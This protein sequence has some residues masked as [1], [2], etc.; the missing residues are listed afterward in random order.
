[1]PEIGK[2]GGG[3]IL[4]GMFPFPEVVVDAETLTNEEWLEYRR[5][6]IGGSDA[7][8]LMYEATQYQDKRGLFHE[9]VG[10]PKVIDTNEDKWFIF[11]FGH[12]VEPLVAEMFQ[13]ITG[14]EVYIDTNMYR[15][16]VYKFMQANVDRVV[17]LPDGK[18]ALL[19]CKTTTFF[20]KDVWA[21]GAIP[22]AYE[23]QCRHYMAVMDVDVMFIACIYGNTPG[24]FV[25]RRI[26][27]D[28]EM[29]RDLIEAEK[30]F[31]ENYVELGREPE[32]SGIGELELEF[33]KR[34]G[35]YAEKTKPVVDFTGDESYKPLIE[36]YLA[37]DKE[38]KELQARAKNIET[39]QKGMQ[40]TFAEKLGTACKGEYDNGDGTYFA[41][42]YSPRSQKS[43]DYD[44][45]ALV[46]PEAYADCITVN[47]EGSRVFSIKEKKR[48]LLKRAV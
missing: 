48:R 38:R 19:E 14:F 46:Y 25:V 37:L 13:R 26:E 47:A 3:K 21:N 5:Q 2:I 7:A 11:Q 16:P 43:V 36:E 20:N 45:L 32:P 4:K 35:G 42:D 34:Y 8:V 15:H 22:R 9:K 1:M 44:K 40:A 10:T 28:M 33:L 39:M 30:D 24:D 18:P 41:I 6:G 17:I 12:T 27:R 31:W 23:M 29:E